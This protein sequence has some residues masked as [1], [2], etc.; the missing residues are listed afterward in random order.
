MFVVLSLVIWRFQINLLPLQHKLLVMDCTKLER[1]D[2]DGQKVM[3]AKKQFNTLD[4][5]IKAAKIDNAKPER[6]S[7]V[8]AYKCPTCH[9]YHVG[10]NGKVLTE[11]E[12]AKYQ[13]EI[14]AE[15]KIKALQEENLKRNPYQRVKVVGFIDLTK[16][17]Y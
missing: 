1:I 10:R 17:K 3:Q 15:S 2:E 8:V 7:K 5:A 13:R 6:L 12:K 14:L 16:I 4:D 9:K 11:K